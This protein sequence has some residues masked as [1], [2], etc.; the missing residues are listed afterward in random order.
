MNSHIFCF[1]LFCSSVFTMKYVIVH[2]IGQTG[3]CVNRAWSH[4][5]PEAGSHPIK[6]HLFDLNKRLEALALE[7][8]C[9]TCTLLFSK[10]KYKVFILVECSHVQ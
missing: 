4:C 7:L 9:D 8:H 3:R 10:E 2:C 1:S 5:S 6:H